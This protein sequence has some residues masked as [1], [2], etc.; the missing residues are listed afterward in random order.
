MATPTKSKTPPRVS[1]DQTERVHEPQKLLVARRALL[2][3][4]PAAA[5]ALTGET[6]ERAPRTKII[7]IGHL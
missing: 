3:A 4:A 5:L 6:P 1:E 7:W 2:V